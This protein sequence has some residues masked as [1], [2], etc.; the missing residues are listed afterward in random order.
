[1]E[2]ALAPNTEALLCPTWPGR[3]RHC[4]PETRYSGRG[5][6]QPNRPPISSLSI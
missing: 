6:D 1:L 4:A 3:M 2:T 5:P